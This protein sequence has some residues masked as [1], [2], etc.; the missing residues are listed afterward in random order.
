MWVVYKVPP[1]QILIY[2]RRKLL[3]FFSDLHKIQAPPSAAQ[4]NVVGLPT[5]V[6]IG[7]CRSIFLVSI[8]S[9]VVLMCLS[10]SR[11]PEAE[12]LTQ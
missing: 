9:A 8:R 10:I 7:G 3:L 2:I 1:S 6:V 5:P 12:P 11:L 4:R